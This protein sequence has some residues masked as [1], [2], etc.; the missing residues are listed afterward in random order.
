MQEV[1]LPTVPNPS[2][3]SFLEAIASAM[4]ISSVTVF[5]YTHSLLF[6]HR[7]LPPF[8]LGNLSSSRRRFGAFL[9]SHVEQPLQ[10]ILQ[11]LNLLLQF[12]R[13]RIVE[14]HLR[15]EVTF[16][17]A[18]QSFQVEKHLSAV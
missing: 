11:I 2:R 15:G 8:V 14:L 1:K 12:F 6:L 7:F 10:R 16:Q 3:G 4:A 9:V 18:D 17:R 5:G 13:P